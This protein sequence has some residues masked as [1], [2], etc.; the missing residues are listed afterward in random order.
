MC[1]R[2]YLADGVRGLAV[3]HEPT[4]PHGQGAGTELVLAAIMRLIAERQRQRDVAVLRG[5]VRGGCGCVSR[6]RLFMNTLRPWVCRL[7]GVFERL[8]VS[9]PAGKGG[10]G[11]V[12]VSYTHLTLPTILRV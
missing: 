4:Q 6:P 3:T 10:R 5:P 7:L 11:R 12:A 9:G 8:S 1:L 2:D